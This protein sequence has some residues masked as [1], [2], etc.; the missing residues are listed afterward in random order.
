[1][2]LIYFIYGGS[3]GSELQQKKEKFQHIYHCVCAGI[4]VRA[5]AIGLYMF[6]LPTLS[7]SVYHFNR[8]QSDKCFANANVPKEER[9]VYRLKID[10]IFV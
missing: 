7:E 6:I 4:C 9:K 5:C 2:A 1:M 8:L 10:G 3:V